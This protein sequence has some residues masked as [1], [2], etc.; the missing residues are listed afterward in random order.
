VYT[1]RFVPI[2]ASNP[3]AA[4]LRPSG[5]PVPI[6]DG[7]MMVNDNYR[8]LSAL[9][10]DE[11]LECRAVQDARF[12]ARYVDALR[13]AARDDGVEVRPR[14]DGWDGGFDGVRDAFERCAARGD[15]VACLFIQDVFLEEVAIAL[16]EVLAA[17]AARIGAASLAGVIEKAIIPGERVRMARGLKEVCKRVPEPAGRTEAFRRAA[18]EIVPALRV[19]SDVPASQPC[20]RTCRTC[21]DHCLKVDA[22]CGEVSLDGCWS[23]ILAGITT[24]VQSVG[25]GRVAA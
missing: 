6:A 20:A 12:A 11:S 22:C 15:V 1:R 5:I 8:R 16:Y 14:D 13:S 23:R 17:S 9:V 2:L 25:I 7:Q 19:F 18:A 4:T 21:G 3:L 10:P 24:A